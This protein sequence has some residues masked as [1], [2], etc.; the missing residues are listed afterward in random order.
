MSASNNTRDHITIG[1]RQSQLAV[2]QAEYVT[3][4][5]R[6][7]Y[8][9][10]DVSLRFFVTKGDRVLDKPLPEIGGKGLFTAELE[11]ALRAGEIDLAVHSLKDL[12]TDMAEGFILGATTPREKPN[13]VLISRDGK[14]LDELPEG[15]V[16]GTSS[17][18]R[19]AQ[20]KAVQPDL[21]TESLRGN[22]PTRINKA[23]DP[24]GPYDAIILAFAGVDR[25]KLS[26]H[27]T[28][29]L[30]TEIM[31]PAPAQGALGIQ[32][33]ADDE[34]MYSIL[35]PLNHDETRIA[36]EAERTFLNRLDSGCRLP[37]AALSWIENGRLILIGRVANL[38]GDQVITVRR[39]S[40]E[41]TRESAVQLGEQIADEAI[42]RG[43]NKLLDEI[44]GNIEA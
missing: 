32:C 28:Q 34:W 6:E 41:I 40:A 4:L 22:V 31:L 8:P 37:V 16:V 11:S 44:R 42:Q 12:P 3:S 35:A 2:W 30:P 29:I 17:L 7:R 39:D 38:D 5:L 36:V 10:L 26:Q 9:A 21:K 1:T 24:N 23:L 13:D 15:A 19:V 25:L 33:R 20:L 43:A 14:K 18:R 27:I